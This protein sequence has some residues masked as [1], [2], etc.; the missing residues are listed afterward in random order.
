MLVATAALGAGLAAAPATAAAECLDLPVR[1]CVP[2][3]GPPQVGVATDNSN[4]YP[5]L[6]SAEAVRIKFAGVNSPYGGAMGIEPGLSHASLNGGTS[7]MP[8]KGTPTSIPNVEDPING[9][10]PYKA[11]C[12]N[13]VDPS[14]YRSGLFGGGLR[15]RVPLFE[16]GITVGNYDQTNGC[17][18]VCTHRW[19][20]RLTR[21]DVEI[22]L[23]KR[24]PATGRV[25]TDFDY[26]RPRFTATSF[27]HAR[28][29]GVLESVDFGT[30]TP[31]KAYQRGAARL[32]GLIF[33]KGTTRAAAGR[34]RFS[35]FEN[36]ANGR[37]STGQPLQAFSVFTSTGA[38][39]STG[40][41]YAGSYKL[42]LRDI[43]TNR[44]V[45]L[46][47]LPLPSMGQ[48]VDI[49]LDRPAFGIPRARDVAC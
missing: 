43:E 28:P 12:E 39:Y 40:T 34:V 26:V 47:H 14:Y 6:R 9:G 33:T 45:V 37:T 48:R 44:C 11:A 23:K 31:L 36:D 18:A 7:Y 15:K 35:M 38:Y 49:R 41:V 20:E 22:Y 16:N 3:T 25:S 2:P 24:D 30:I 4:D 8:C 21:F 27:P 19:A 10:E 17:I 5:A 1:V 46:K 42:R 13:T 32:Q 29:G